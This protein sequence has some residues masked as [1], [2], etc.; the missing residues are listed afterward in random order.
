[1]KRLRSL[2]AEA[3]RTTKGVPHGERIPTRVKAETTAIQNPDMGTKSP[4]PSTSMATMSPGA[5]D[6]LGIP[7]PS[8][9]QTP[10]EVLLDKLRGMAK[11]TKK[12]PG[13]LHA[14]KRTANWVH[15]MKSDR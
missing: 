14:I 15:G 4:Q 9:P 12:N 3:R 6:V 1:M 8:M 7:S 10:P 2:V 11:G 5:P 13:R